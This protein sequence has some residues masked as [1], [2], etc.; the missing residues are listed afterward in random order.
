MHGQ[1]HI[2]FTVNNSL[3]HTDCMFSHTIYRKKKFDSATRNISVNHNPSTN[4]LRHTPCS[5][6]L[7]EKLIGSQLVK[8]FPAFYGT[9]RFIT[10]FTSVHRLSLLI[11]NRLQDIN[12]YIAYVFIAFTG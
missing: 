10:A 11:T 4:R 9:R 3:L 5:R 2:R 8:K 6:V 7:L 12:I 1:P